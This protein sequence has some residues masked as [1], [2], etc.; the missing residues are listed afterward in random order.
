MKENEFDANL[1]FMAAVG[2]AVRGWLS[3]SQPRPRRYIRRD[4]HLTK[5]GPGRREGYRPGR[6]ELER[7][8]E[9]GVAAASEYHGRYFKRAG[10]VRNA[11]KLTR[12]C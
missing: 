7:R 10:K 11:K 9:E 5:T 3:P 4:A 1:S 12:G 2:R 6:A 8:L